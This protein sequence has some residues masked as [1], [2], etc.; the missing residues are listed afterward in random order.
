MKPIK[1]TEAMEKFVQAAM[2]YRK[3]HNELELLREE[4][5]YSVKQQQRYLSCSNKAIEV[6]NERDL[7]LD[8][9]LDEI[10]AEE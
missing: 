1:Q 2:E 6:G 3:L 8:D 10:E 5:L 9:W 4:G 7:Q